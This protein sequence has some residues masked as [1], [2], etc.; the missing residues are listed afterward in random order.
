MGALK[1]DFAGVPLM[2]LTA[3]ATDRVRQDVISNLGMDRPLV[4]TASFNRPNLKYEVR[5]KTKGFVNEI[6]AFVQ[7]HKRE[8][9][10]IYCASQ[11][12]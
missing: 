8:C 6:I 7:Q 4:L 11:K 3:T 10:I 9:G 12:L 5:P 1:H 2:A